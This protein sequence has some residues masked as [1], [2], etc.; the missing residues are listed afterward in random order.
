MSL[1]TAQL[2][3]LKNFIVADPVMSL[4]PLNSDGA[5][6]IAALLNK[7]AAPAFTMWKTNVSIASVG[8]A[9]DGGELGNLTTANTSRITAV[10]GFFMQ[11]GLNPSK[12]DIR[13]MWD[14]IF[15]TGG[16]TKASLLV[17]WKRFATVY[18]KLFATGTGTDLAPA[19]PGV[20]GDA[21]Q[22]VG[23]V[24]ADVVQRARAS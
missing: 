6:D 14:D 23:N 15:S 16:V 5:F 20:D 22:I 19:T 1:T 21:L 18:E 12:A 17:L 24:S 4:K 10:Q 8:D 9:I 11:R 3:T 2:T 13:K 7:Q